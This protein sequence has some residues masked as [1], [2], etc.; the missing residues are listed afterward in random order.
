MDEVTERCRKKQEELQQ[1]SAWW[2]RESHRGGAGGV[3]GVVEV[4]T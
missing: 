2:T 3:R 4:K 1:L